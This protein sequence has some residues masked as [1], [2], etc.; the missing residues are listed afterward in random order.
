MKKALMISSAPLLCAFA[1][2]SSNIQ[3][4][5]SSGFDNDTFVYD[6]VD[7]KKSTITFEHFRTWSLGDLFMFVDLTDGTKLD[8]TTKYEA[9]TEIS[10]R[11]SLSKI[12]GSDL[13]A[14]VFGDWYLSAQI[15]SGNGYTA[16][17]YGVGTDIS[18]PKF[19]FFSLNLYQK[20]QNFGDDTCQVSLAYRTN[21]F[22][23]FHFDGYADITDYDVNTQHQLLYNVG[24]K[25]VKGGKL[26]VGTEWFYYEEND[27]DVSTA[28]FQ[29]M[30]KYRF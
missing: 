5:Y 12:S 6:T 19:D 25:F 3:Y 30:A 15:N 23:G 1:F 16:W 7:G 9:Y 26:F 28:L 17:L 13:S 10:P 18:I 8:H 24:Q 11:L 2:E 21:E 14:G 22:Y 27:A 4:L 29:I 20:S